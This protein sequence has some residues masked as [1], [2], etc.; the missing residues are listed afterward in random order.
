MPPFP[1]KWLIVLLV[2]GFGIPLL[3]P[4]LPYVVSSYR[5]FLVSTMSTA[6]RSAP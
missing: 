3:N 1:K 6:T 5:L 2:L 4:L